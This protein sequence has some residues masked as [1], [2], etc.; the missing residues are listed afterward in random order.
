[1]CTTVKLEGKTLVPH[2]KNPDKAD[3][4]VPDLKQNG[5]VFKSPSRIAYVGGTGSGKTNCL[6]ACLGHG[7]QWKAWK[8]IFLLS[9]NVESTIKGEYGILDD[10][11]PL[12]EWP[13]INYFDKYPGRKVLIAD[14]NA[15][16]GLPTRGGTDSQRNRADRI[17][18]HVSTHKNLTICICQQT[19]VGIPP[20]IRRLMSH[21]VLFPNRIS[22]ESIPLIARSCMLERKH[23]EQLFA[24]C[25]GDYDFILIENEPV[26]GRAR[27][28]INGNRAVLG[29]N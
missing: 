29:I 7:A 15:L 28:R 17:C 24:W 8:H 22:H 10:V 26:K 11:I 14:D 12:T 27:V 23:L 25:T 2:I 13:A 18:G 3:H 4:I 20:N 9:P 16:V 6:L 21:F 1:M 19:M 5:L